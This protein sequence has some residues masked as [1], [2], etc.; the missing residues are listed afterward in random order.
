MIKQLVTLA[1]AAYVAPCFAAEGW[2]VDDLEA[3][4]K[5]ALE[6]NKDLIIEFT[7][8]DWC[9]PC[10]HLR[11]TILTT[12]E[13]IEAA[14]KNFVLAELDYP[15]KKQ[16][17]PEVKAAND[18]LAQK[19]NVSGFP[20]VVFADANGKPFE[21]FVG[22]PSKAEVMAAL[23]NS[24]KKKQ[25]LKDL[26]AKVE[27][28]KDKDAKMEALYAII[29]AAPKPF[30]NS[31]YGNVKNELMA[32]DRDDKYGF[33]AAEEKAERLKK[34]EAALKSYM[35]QN[36]KQNMSPSEAVE[37]LKKFPNREQLLPESQQRLLMMEFGATMNAMGDVDAGVAILDKLI[38]IDP[39]SKISKQA[40][41]TKKNIILNRD[42]IKQ[43]HEQRLKAQSL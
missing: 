22:A 19:Y 27:S 31:F 10:K 18:L 32:L 23:T 1:V 13:F 35:R 14:S 6:Q 16:Q 24:L 25:E 34:D 37:I 11:A 38:S 26:Q 21:A 33:R 29:K 20:T 2:I 9:P 41:Y 7:G 17:S 28:A 5:Q 8:S 12:P 30:V 40:E 42:K 36:M 43:Q 3:A 39:N 15:Q 4:K